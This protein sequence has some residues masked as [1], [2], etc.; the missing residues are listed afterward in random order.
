MSSFVVLGALTGGCVPR[1]RMCTA[2]AE[3][4][5]KGACVA[6]RCQV[7]K[8]TLKPAVDSA[9]R[10]V[11]RPIDIG[12]TRTGARST[13]ALPSVVGLG[14]DGGKLFLRFA[15]ALPPSANVVEAYVVLHRSPLVDDD[16]TPISVHAS[17]II[18]PWVG[19]SISWGEQPR[20]AEGRAPA[21]TVEPGGS[22]LVRLDVRDLVRRWARRD[23]SD[24][25][26]AIVAEN[27]SATGTT[28]ALTALGGGGTA[29]AETGAIGRAVLSTPA[30]D[31]EPYLE[32]YVR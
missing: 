21:T 10:L 19:G 25:G 8:V 20:S 27:E 31:P 2:S 12:F 16:P 7:E 24:Q 29:P 11:V 26:I 4:G 5:E 9:R 3:C 1:P 22:P 14:K 6:G 15:V 23:P 32:L 18:D 17:R 28:F 30:P 13:G